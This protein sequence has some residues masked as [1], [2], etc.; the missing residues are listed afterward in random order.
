MSA[1]L[2]DSKAAPHRTL[3]AA[4][5]RE[6]QRSAGTRPVLEWLAEQIGMSEEELLPIAARH[7]GMRPL[8]MAELR[9]LKPDFA[10]ASFADCKRR[11]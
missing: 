10:L 8:G 2:V 7:F 11:G 4:L 3:D 1:V 9:L 5:V 6:A